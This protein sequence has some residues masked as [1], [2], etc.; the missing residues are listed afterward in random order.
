M[1]TK[2]FLVDLGLTIDD[3][4]V[5]KHSLNFGFIFRGHHIKRTVDVVDYLPVCPE[6]SVRYKDPL[7]PLGPR[8]EFDCWD[9]HLFDKL[10]KHGYGDDLL[11][12]VPVPIANLG[13]K[14]ANKKEICEHYQKV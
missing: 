4:S 8:I 14:N 3:K 7:R 9:N 5:E 2:R 10:V 6:T 1:I 13:F 11:S 12:D